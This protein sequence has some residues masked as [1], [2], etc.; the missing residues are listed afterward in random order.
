MTKAIIEALA[1]R[2]QTLGTAE[3]LTG[4]LLADAFISVPGASRVMMGGV[5]AYDEGRKETLLGVKHDT[6]AKHTAVSR[7][8][9]LEMARGARE[10]LQVDYAVS[11]TGYAGPDG[12]DVG[13]VY[14][15]YCGTDGECVREH[16]FAG[17]RRAIR[18]QAVQAAIELLSEHI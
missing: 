8:T 16:R 1:Q 2:R 9:A 3:S 11:T 13:L 6:L 4:G 15:G 18:E 14:V 12:A 17:D 5:V 10:K 7:E